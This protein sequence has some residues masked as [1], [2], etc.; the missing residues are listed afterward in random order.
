MENKNKSVRYAFYG[1]MLPKN[2]LSISIIGIFTAL[3]FIFTFWLQIPIPA[4]GGYINIGDT[5]VMFTALLFGP[6][7]GGIAGGLG[8]TLADILSPYVIYAPAT[9]IIKG[10]EGFLIGLISNPRDREERISFWDILAVLIGGILIP[11][12]Y[13]IYEAFIL[14]LGVVTAFVEIPGNFF[15]FGFAAIASILLILASRKTIIES[16]PQVFDK[17][18]IKEI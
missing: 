10:I 1:Y 17:L 15:Q 18:F 3:N 2:S 5:V 9:L 14:G 16:M 11:F 6:I 13:F 8:P 12:G 4:T 7:I